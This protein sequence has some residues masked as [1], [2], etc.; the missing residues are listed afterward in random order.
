MKLLNLN[1]KRYIFGL[2]LDFI[3]LRK[4]TEIL[5]V[6]QYAPVGKVIQL[7]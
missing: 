5:S 6:A 4:P 3:V 1:K 2:G 7:N